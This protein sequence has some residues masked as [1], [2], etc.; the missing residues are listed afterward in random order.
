M[1][2]VRVKRQALLRGERVPWLVF[3]L[4]TAAFFVIYHD[5]SIAKRAVDDYN[6][7]P[8][9]IIATVAQGQV[10][11]RI[12][13]L[14]LGAAAVASLTWHQANKRFKIRNVL[15]WFL[16]GFLAWAFLSPIWADDLSQNLKRLVV[17]AILALAAVAVVQRISLSEIILW[18]CFSTSVFLSVGFIAEVVF[19][20]FH[21]FASGYRFSGSLYPNG[22]GI[23]CG[24]LLLSAVAAADLEK[25][26]R[27]QFWACGLVGFVFL[28]LTG[29]R[30]SLGAI[31]LSLVIYLFAVRSS[32]TKVK[33]VL[34]AS[35]VACLLL[36]LGGAGLIPGLTNA[37]ML[38]RDDDPG[39]LDT[40]TGRTAI[41][42]D[43]GRYIG[44][45]PIL[46][47]G[48][49]GFWTP[50]HI[51]AVSDEE[52]WGV[53]NSHSAYIDYL[54]MLGS[55]GL[56]AYILILVLGILRA[57]RCFRLSRSPVY[58]FCAA[59]LI[60]AAIDGLFESEITVGSLLM[61][62]WM[63]IL[64]RLAFV[65]LRWNPRLVAEARSNVDR[66]RATHTIPLGQY[67]AAAID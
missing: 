46:G 49:G 56:L 3:I 11:R 51:N 4:L 66:A 12:A 48:Y 55:V 37:A 22:Q 47:Y 8:D 65:P 52:K 42:Q 10:G 59:V 50:A 57:F 53:G 9:E 25:R 5:V 62:L 30:T 19:G 40:F 26:W 61:F 67:G 28:I 63:L 20:S 14:F 44:Q 35:L 18:T 16:I 58:A 41:W 36:F 17:F 34:S 33:M 32:T 23:N 13:L 54:L 38:G 64:I 6:P 7:S 45:S 31:L 43:V 21:P 39:S 29:S 27:W 2:N 24:L 15:G 60:F 1:S